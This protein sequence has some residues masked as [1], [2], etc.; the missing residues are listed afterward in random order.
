MSLES[1]VRHFQNMLQKL[2]KREKGGDCSLVYCIFGDF[3]KLGDRSDLQY[4]YCNI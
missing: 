4:V 3:K 2:Q 1:S